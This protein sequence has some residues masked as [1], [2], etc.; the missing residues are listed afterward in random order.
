MMDAGLILALISAV[1]FAIGI[2]MVRRAA[3]MAG[4][5]FTVTAMSIFAGIPL[6]IVAISAGN[7]WNS[8][9]NISVKAAVMLAAAG[10]IHFVLGR[11]SGYE[12]FRLIGANRA[13]PIT[14]ISP[15]I[16]LF[17]SWIFLREQ[18][19]YFIAFGAFLMVSGVVLISQERRSL[20]G[21]K[22]MP[23]REEIKG[24]LLSLSAA[25]C[26]G[27]TPVLIKPSVEE[28]GSAAVGNIVSYLAAGLGICLLLFKA[29][30]RSDF[31]R[32]SLKKN[33]LPMFL[34][35]LF[36]AAGQLFYFMA[37]Q[38]SPANIVTPL[39]SIEV[40]FIYII[41]YFANRRGEIFTV[42]VALGMIAMVV[43]TFLLFR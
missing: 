37:L 28:I 1:S 21:Q 18:P 39:V 8:L 4:E 6:F 26:W 27:I 11:L 15:I 42:K 16:T 24:I 32:L 29:R 12:A 31:S 20:S 5:A 9:G 14:Q 10:I 22:K 41:S 7:G 13:T 34:A 30:R 17:L 38:R 23:G 19:T 25:L 3:G 36:T 33:I 40:L 2:V 35:G 43:G